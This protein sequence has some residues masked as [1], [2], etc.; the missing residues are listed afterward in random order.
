MKMAGKKSR[1]SAIEFLDYLAQKGLMAHATVQA[2]KA[3]VNAVLGILEEQEAQDVTSINLDDVMIR[4]GNLQGKGYTPQSLVTYKG[5]VKAALEDFASYVDN[6]LAFKPNIQVRERK[7]TSGKASPGATKNDSG[8]P[9]PGVPRP[10]IQAV[11]GP[12]AS[13]ILPIPIRADLTI[14][15]Q[16][17]PFD[18]TE[19]EAKKIANVIQ[20]MAM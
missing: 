16:G 14:H 3:A 19:A 20:A 11:S 7:Q 5:R 15:I 13:S 10:I 9:A 18:L 2:R 12:M 6:P 1:E 8:S 4:F 17:L